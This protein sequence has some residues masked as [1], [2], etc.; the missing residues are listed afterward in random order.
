MQKVREELKWYLFRDIRDV[1]TERDHLERIECDM[2][3]ADI[4][5]PMTQI[6]APSEVKRRFLL[7]FAQ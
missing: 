5:I 3:A 7:L 2:V 1:I 4:P 6:S